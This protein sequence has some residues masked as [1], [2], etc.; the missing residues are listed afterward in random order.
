M[1]AAVNAIHFHYLIHRFSFKHRNN[2]KL[3]LTSQLKK[4]QKL[5]DTINVI[6]CSD[7]YLLKINQE[8][9]QHDFYTDIITF[10]LSPPKARLVS[11]IY[12]SIERVREN[13]KAY[14]VSFTKELHRI[15]FH[16]HL[17]LCGFDDKAPQA[18][19]MMSEK[20]QDWLALYFAR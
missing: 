18:K 2:L 9:L 11:D 5:V 3:F 10:E 7:Q 1:R 15:I 20:E 8:Y 4:E 12:I 16:G 6:F 13:A 19:K 17:H 14:K